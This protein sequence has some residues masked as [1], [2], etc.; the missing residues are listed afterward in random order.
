MEKQYWQ[1]YCNL[2][3]TTGISQIQDCINK[4]G[5]IEDFKFFSDISISF[6]VEIEST[7]IE[8]LYTELGKILELEKEDKTSFSVSNTTKVLLNITFTKGKGNMR[9]EVIAVPG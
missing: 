5:S 3:R 6:V 4:F 9:N 2:D 1:G 8:M 7:K